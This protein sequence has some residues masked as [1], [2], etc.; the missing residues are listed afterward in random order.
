MLGLDPSRLQRTGIQRERERERKGHGPEIFFADVGTYV[1]SVGGAAFK[2]DF[3]GKTRFCT[4]RETFLR[5]SPLF[6]RSPRYVP[7]KLAE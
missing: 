1:R 4:R 2:S 6:P 7:G 5:V 3:D